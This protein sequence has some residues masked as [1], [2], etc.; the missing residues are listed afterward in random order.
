VR[1]RD[2]FAA[3]FALQ[4]GFGRDRPVAEPYFF[5]PCVGATEIIPRLRAQRGP[6]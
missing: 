3:T 5:V 1:A 4:L 6:R 2:K